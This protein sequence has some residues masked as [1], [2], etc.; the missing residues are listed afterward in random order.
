MKTRN[1]YYDNLKF[2][3]MILVVLSHFGFEQKSEPSMHALLNVLAAFVVP[4]YAV[5]SG[6]F[7]RKITAQR[8]EDVLTLLV[9]YLVLEVMHLGFTKVT[10]MGKGDVHFEVPTYQNWYLLTLFFWRMMAPYFRFVKPMAGVF[11]ALCIGFS[12]GFFGSFNDFLD[13]HRTLYFFPFFIVG[14]YTEDLL[15]VVEKYK[16]FKWLSMV[17]FVAFVSAISYFTVSNQETADKLL[18]LFAP[19]F[20]YGKDLGNFVLR[21]GAFGVTAITV[22]AFLSIMTNKATFFTKFGA[23]TF[24]VYLFHM[25]LVWPLIPLI[26]PYTP[27]LSEVLAVVLSLAIT[28]TLSSSKLEPILKPITNPLSLFA[29]KANKDK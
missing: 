18:Y 24:N 28:F 7:S 3:L 5:I 25:F 19:M 10:G 26:Q 16:S 8:K 9:P 17:Y 13:L 20:G 12:V 27:I 1:P 21:L 11:I 23:N 29:T 6:F 2:I 4:V 22:F 15:A 14:Y